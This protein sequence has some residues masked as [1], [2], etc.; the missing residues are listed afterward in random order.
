MEE[1]E[2]T[3]PGVIAF[4]HFASAGRLENSV[5]GTAVRNDETETVRGAITRWLELEFGSSQDVADAVVSS[6]GVGNDPSLVPAG[7]ERGADAY[8]PDDFIRFR[9]G[10]DTSGIL[11][12]V[13]PAPEQ[14][15]MRPE[16]LALLTTIAPHL[17]TA[18]TAAT[19]RA[20]ACYAQLVTLVDAFHGPAFLCTAEPAIIKANTAAQ[21]YLA[22]LGED[23]LE[24]MW[25]H[26]DGAA[27]SLADQLEA[28]GS[29]G[30]ISSCR[31]SAG[32]FV[33]VEAHRA[34]W[35]PRC[36][37]LDAAAQRDLG[38]A[39]PA[40]LVHL[41]VAPAV[42]DDIA[43][44]AVRALGITPAELRL[45]LRLLNGSTLQETAEHF[46][47]SYNTLRNQLAS[48]SQKTGLRTQAD[49]VRFFIPLKS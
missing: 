11:S 12:I 34:G 48:L 9:T 39:P 27:A 20:L 14:R 38:F 17:G 44:E 5:G 46:G 47:V 6:L 10:E 2:R 29:A 19:H 1:L 37:A 23:P 18:W 30:G 31:D 41:R 15:R 45:L 33:I 13:Y 7:R 36:L 43:P 26:S 28:D 40:F 22:S 8:P 4:L 3:N 21:Q 49:I 16:T 35:Q 32:N 42:A 24:G 25:R